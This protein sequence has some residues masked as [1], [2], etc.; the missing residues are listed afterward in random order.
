MQERSEKGKADEIDQR[1]SERLKMRRLFLGLSQQDLG[2]AVNVSIQQIQKYE[3]AIN[4]ISCGKLYTMARLLKTPISYFFEPEHKKAEEFNHQ[5]RAWTEEHIEFEY[6]NCNLIDISD[7]RAITLLRFYQD[8]KDE[9]LRQRILN[10][11]KAV[12]LRELSL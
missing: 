5:S 10:L 8:I 11:V 2:D 7:K 9:K 1:V 4:R 12:S 6:D 3:K